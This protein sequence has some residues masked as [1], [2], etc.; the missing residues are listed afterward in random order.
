MNG[1]ATALALHEALE[2][3]SSDGRDVFVDEYVAAEFLNLAVRT[4]RNQRWKGGGAP[5]RKFGAAVRYSLRDLQNYVAPTF[6]STA[7]IPRRKFNNA[8]KHP[9]QI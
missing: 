4:L 1:N 8:D 5:F 2:K 9:S 7:Q 3:L 6:R